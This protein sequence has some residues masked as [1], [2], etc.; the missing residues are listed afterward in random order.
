MINVDNKYFKFCLGTFCAIGGVLIIIILL[1]SIIR[2]DVIDPNKQY[3]PNHNFEVP[4]KCDSVYIPTEED[5]MEL[6]TML[7]QVN[8][9][10]LDID[11]LHIRIDRIEDKIDDLI[12]EQMKEDENSGNDKT[13]EDIDWTGTYQDE[14][15]IW[16]SG[17]GDTIWE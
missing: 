5:I 10:E 3:G 4:V 17:N 13:K 6:D 2:G 14:Y 11:T 7:N 12:E 9:I 1:N 8:N 16:V 15:V